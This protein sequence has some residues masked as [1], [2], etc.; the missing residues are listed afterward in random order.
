MTNWEENDRNVEELSKD[1]RDG[2]ISK[3]EAQRRADEL[4]KEQ[5]QIIDGA[6]K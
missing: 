2:N 6:L 1:M 3:K 4:L 5:M